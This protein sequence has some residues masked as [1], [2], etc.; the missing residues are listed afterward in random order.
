[1]GLG[2]CRYRIFGTLIALDDLIG[3]QDITSVLENGSVPHTWPLMALRRPTW[4][5][6]GHPLPLS[7]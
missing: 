6:D 1:M 7:A 5:R 4:L 2:M 3:D